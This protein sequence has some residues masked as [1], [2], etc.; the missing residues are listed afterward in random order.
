M[1]RERC[2]ATSLTQTPHLAP[3]ASLPAGA[4]AGEAGDDLQVFDLIGNAAEWCQDLYTPGHDED[5]HTPGVG[6][7]HVIRGAGFREFVDE[8]CRS[9]WRANVAQ[10]A[11]R[12]SV[13]A[14][15]RIWRES[16]HEALQQLVLD[17][18]TNVAEMRSGS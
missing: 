14:W 4:A 7:F 12:T 1:A 3:V 13:F 9:T 11:L 2:C 16:F 15:R 6:E 5:R 18:S 10:K 17:P 8:R